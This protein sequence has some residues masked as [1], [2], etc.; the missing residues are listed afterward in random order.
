MCW[1]TTLT[2]GIAGESAEG[3]ALELS[4]ALLP[5]NIAR[6]D[7]EIVGCLPHTYPGKSWGLDG[8]GGFGRQH[9]FM[10]GQSPLKRMQG[11]ANPD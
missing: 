2:D 7:Q 8:V 4:P 10:S 1:W 5:L 9:A 3:K 6:S 11:F